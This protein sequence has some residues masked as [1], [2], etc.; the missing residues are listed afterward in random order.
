M[1]QAL[2]ELRYQIIAFLRQTSWRGAELRRKILQLNDIIE[3]ESDRERNLLLTRET[4]STANH[5]DNIPGVMTNCSMQMHISDITSKSDSSLK[6]LV[7][8]ITAP[9]EAS[10]IQSLINQTTT[11]DGIYPPRRFR[12]A[13]WQ[14]NNRFEVRYIRE[15]ST[16]GC[17]LRNDSPII[18]R[19]EPVGVYAG[20]LTQQSG[21]YVM[22]L[23]PGTLV[24]G[25]QTWRTSCSC[26][27]G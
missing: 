9:D 6:D 25:M 22:Q 16:L 8:L 15:I 24:D 3:L 10:A 21:E 2:E 1:E 7:S 13:L 19:G 11:E 14:H 12:T 26:Y 20:S 18:R 4:D 23:L 17:F 5:E 27:H